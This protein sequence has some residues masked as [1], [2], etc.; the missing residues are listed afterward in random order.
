MG[1][2]I[3][4][5]V[6]ATDDGGD[7]WYEY[8]AVDYY[9]TKTSITIKNAVGTAVNTYDLEIPD[10]DFY[11]TEYEVDG[12]EVH[13]RYVDPFSDTKSISLSGVDDVYLLLY[14]DEGGGGGD[15]GEI[16][17]TVYVG[18]NYYDDVTVYFD[19][20]TRVYR[21]YEAAIDEG[22]SIPSSAFISTWIQDG[23]GTE[24]TRTSD[25]PPA[26]DTT[27]VYVGDDT[28]YVEFYYEAPPSIMVTTYLDGEVYDQVQW[29][30][31][32]GSYD[33]A[34]VY[35][36]AVNTY[37]LI[38]PPGSEFSYTAVQ[39]YDGDR[40]TSYTYPTLDTSTKVWVNGSY[41]M[42]Y[43]SFYYTMPVITTKVRIYHNGDWVTATPYV[44]HNGWTEAQDKIYHNNGWQ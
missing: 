20:T 5:Y 9:T 8:D 23:D 43:V 2:N 30:L 29:Q 40:R 12:G 4:V 31:D 28:A 35:Y 1:A 10:G 16:N 19:D 14:Y 7:S 3:Y 39:D 26:D 24:D 11:F 36:V 22:L 21:V 37:G 18:G 41:N 27:R 6:Y 34:G 44:Y 13:T 32:N 38:A 42:A 17:V 25:D 15:Y 33:L